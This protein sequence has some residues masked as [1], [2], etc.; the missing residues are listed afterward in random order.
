V[1]FF[2][3]GKRGRREGEGTLQLPL[4]PSLAGIQEKKFTI[5]LVFV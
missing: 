2:S 1:R 4:N 5:V 3:K